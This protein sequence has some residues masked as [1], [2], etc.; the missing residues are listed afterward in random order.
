MSHI[1]SQTQEEEP[2]NLEDDELRF[3]S[4]EHSKL[5]ALDP[6][7]NLFANDRFGIVANLASAKITKHLVHH[8]KHKEK[9]AN[10][11][12]QGCL[13][14]HDADVIIQDVMNRHVQCTNGHTDPD[15]KLQECREGLVP[16]HSINPHHRS[17]KLRQ[18]TPH[19]S[20]A[21]GV[22]THTLLCGPP[23]NNSPKS[24]IDF[25]NNIGLG[26]EVVRS[27]WFGSPQK[28]N[29]WSNLQ[30]KI[31]VFILKFVHTESD[32]YADA[33]KSNFHRKKNITESSRNEGKRSPFQ[34]KSKEPP[35]DDS[36]GHKTPSGKERSSSLVTVRS[37][38]RKMP[39]SS[40]KGKKKAIDKKVGRMMDVASF[41]EMSR[42]QSL[43]NAEFEHDAD[44]ESK[45]KATSEKWNGFWSR[46][47]KMEGKKKR[48]PLTVV[49]SKHRRKKKARSDVF[50][51]M[52][53]RK[54]ITHLLG[55]PDLYH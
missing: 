27:E 47:A 19:C 6:G 29:E 36:I 38:E 46:A 2:T 48:K 5:C 44:A 42:I 25:Y 22:L 8:A 34:V 16:T 41:R 10:F 32:V 11:T 55:N 43:D 49:Q 53:G 12:R 4:M 15:N 14:A 26:V 52:D 31:K 18:L 13:S 3:K 51:M 7:K 35:S 28:R 17:L 21:I 23:P 54:P 45:K 20:W 50:K 37:H 40:I 39:R 30:F 1:I 33:L 9:L 24:Y